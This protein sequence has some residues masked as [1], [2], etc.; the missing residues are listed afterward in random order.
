VGTGKV[1]YSLSTSPPS[2]DKVDSEYKLCT[3]KGGELF[4]LWFTPFH[5]IL[6][7]P[8]VCKKVERW[9]R[10]TKDKGYGKQAGMLC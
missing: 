2:V 6:Y 8:L 5:L 1:F 9:I 4:H 10:V 3:A 7:K